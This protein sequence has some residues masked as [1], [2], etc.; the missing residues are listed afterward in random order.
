LRTGDDPMG[1]FM[2]L[3]NYNHYA[4]V[5]DVADFIAGRVYPLNGQHG[6]YRVTADVGPLDRETYEAG[7]VGSL[8]DAIPAFL[9]YYKKY[10]LRWDRLNDKYCKSTLFT[11]LQVGQD[12]QGNWIAYREY[13]PLLRNGKPAHFA[14]SADAQRA[15]EIHELDLFP[16]AK[17]IDDGFSWLPDPE[18][19][20]RSVPHRVEDRVKWQRSASNFLP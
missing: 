1:T 13:H 3:K 6:P 11:L 9:A 10:P 14:T 12:E 5:N 2:L 20:W 15:A 18:L 19:D 4:I 17:V 7:I 8:D 16:G